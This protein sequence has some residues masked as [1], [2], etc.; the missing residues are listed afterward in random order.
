MFSETNEQQ[1]L[2]SQLSH[3][4]AEGAGWMKFLGV[5]SILAGVPQV[6]SIFG[7]ISGGLQ[8]WMGVLLFQASSS[9]EQAYTMGDAYALRV[10]LQNVKTFFMLN[11]IIALITILLFCAALCFLVLLPMLGVIPFLIDP[12]QFQ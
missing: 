4:L 11:G 2:V 6:L 7:I 8:I 9:A 12:Q 1:R 3:P 10:A 5:L